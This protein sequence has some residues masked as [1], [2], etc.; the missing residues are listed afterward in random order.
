MA[1]EKKMEPSDVE[2][3][4]GQDVEIEVINPDAVSV[5]TDDG[6]LLI[7]FSGEITEELIGPSHDA[8]LAEFLDEAD[9]QSMAA[10]LIGDFDGDRM[11][12]K[13]WARSYVKG[14]DLLGMK[15]EE[16]SQP[17]AGA[18]GVF[19][20]VLTES[21]VRFQAQAMGELFPASGPVRSKVVG[22]QTIEKLQQAKRVENEMNYLLTANRP[23]K[24]KF[25]REKLNSE[26]K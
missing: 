25:L 24:R 17:W 22:K 1:V 6:G 16:R 8:N 7:D 2:V 10:E 9:L 26:I 20:P 14:L 12:R 21:V 4:N 18:S 13:E 11:S 23:I 15:I 5:E 19:H 3:M